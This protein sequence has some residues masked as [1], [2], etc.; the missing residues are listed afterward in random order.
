MAS[1]EEKKINTDTARWSRRPAVRFVNFFFLI[2]VI[3]AFLAAAIAFYSV[4]LDRDI[5]WLRARIEKTLNDRA[6]DGMRVTLA[7]ARIGVLENGSAALKLGGLSVSAA[8]QGFSIVS[9]QLSIR[10]NWLSFLSGQIEIDS[11]QLDGARINVRARASESALVDDFF[12]GEKDLREIAREGAGFFDG[13]NPPSSGSQT[14][15]EGTLPLV[16]AVKARPDK[17]AI[18]ATDEGEEKQGAPAILERISQHLAQAGLVFDK[19]RQFDLGD[20]ALSD[21]TLNLVDA[22][23]GVLRNLVITSLTFS[24]NQEQDGLGVR[25]NIEIAT[26]QRGH[27][28]VR[29]HLSHIKQRL[30]S[31]RAFLFDVSNIIARNFIQRLNQPDYLVEITT[32]FSFKGQ[33]VTSEK[34]GIHQF[35]MTVVAGAGFVTTAPKATFAVNSGVLNLSLNRRDQ[36]LVIEPSPFVF[37]NNKFTAQGE[38]K[39]PLQLGDAYDFELAAYDSYLDSPDA[40]SPPVIIEHIVARGALQPKQKL[41]SVSHFNLKAGAVDFTAAVSFGFDKKTPSMALAG[42]ASDIPIAVFKQLWPIFIAP[43]ARSWALANIH[44]GTVSAGRVDS[45]IPGGVLGRLRK[46]ETIAEDE[47]QLD[48]CLKNASF[49]TFGNF[50]AIEEGDLYGRVRGV[51]FSADLR[52]GVAQSAYGNRVA[53]SGRRFQILDFRFPAPIADIR[54][55]AS[56]KAEDIGEIADRAPVRAL[57]RTGIRPKGLSGDVSAD[58][59]LSLPLRNELEAGEVVWKADLRLNDFTSPEPLDGRKIEKATADIALTPDT[60]NVKGKGLIDGIAADLNLSRP[61]GP[62]GSKGSLAVN[63]KLSNED[64]KKLGIDLE[65]YLDGPVGVAIAQESRGRGDFYKVD[66]SN[67]EIKLD[68][69]GW[70]KAKGVPASAEMRLSFDAKGTRVR[71][72]VISGDGFGASGEIDLGA[73]GEIRKLSLDK[74]ALRGGDD[75]EVSAVLGSDRTYDI[76]IMGAAFD[77]RSLIKVIT[78]TPSETAGESEQYRYKINA[79]VDK[80]I[81]YLGETITALSLD[82]TMRS[83][84]PLKLMAAGITQ[85]ATKPFSITYG[86]VDNRGDVLLASGS[87]GGALAR[88]GNIYYRAFGGNFNL[89]AERPPG[90]T[91]MVGNFRMTSFRLVDEPALKGLSSAKDERGRS[92]VKFDVL[93]I[94]F[95]EENQRLTTTKGLL[96]GENVG[97]TYEGILNR[98]TKEI[99]FTGT[100]V[101]AYVLNNFITKIPI[102]GLALGNGQREGLIGVTFKVAGTLGRPIVTVNPL[103]ALAPGFLRQFFRFKKA[104]EKTN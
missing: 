76:T 37:G 59:T 83:T 25:Q 46:G 56:G 9:D 35:K 38:I 53:I 19:I 29:L 41:I 49:S 47:L 77:A 39:L 50:P 58:V 42:E 96:T 90:A 33:I 75:I 79:A 40:A 11:V 92:S 71:D 22:E 65:G 20:I 55:N 97:G 98:K 43:S 72:F 101:P 18:L 64:R 73:D 62:A 94:A 24:E 85:G 87:D 68:F 48:F 28:G 34:L 13:S 4:N 86:S 84:T 89:S 102:V 95:T 32:P 31:K 104:Q 6:G 93:D 8:N 14:F 103:S 61:L 12:A 27:A 2:A 74:V 7:K 21:I 52:K 88:F 70:R 16:S 82:V 80:V 15:F 57:E 26:R 3:L 60:M 36:S 54:L 91:A 63:V 1:V 17:Q 78:S 5:E 45:A 69:V 66:L 67:A 99:D 30:T 23:G 100:Y 51:S 10:P 81:G 44:K